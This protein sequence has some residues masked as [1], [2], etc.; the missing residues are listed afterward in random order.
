MEGCTK[1]WKYN[2]QNGD[3][4]SIGPL[5]LIM[6]NGICNDAKSTHEQMNSVQCTMLQIIKYK[7]YV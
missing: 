4:I 5:G 2:I 7:D 3:E 6:K 1:T